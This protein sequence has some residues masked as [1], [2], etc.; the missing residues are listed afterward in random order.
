MLALSLVILTL[1]LAILV[2]LSK[3]ILQAFRLIGASKSGSSKW[4]IRSFIQATQKRRRALQ[5]AQSQKK[6]KEEISLSTLTNLKLCFMF[7]ALG[8]NDFDDW[9]AHN[10]EVVQSLLDV[11]D[12]RNTRITALPKLDTLIQRRISLMKARDETQRKIA[13]V[14]TKAASRERGDRTKKG[15]SSNTFAVK[16]ESVSDKDRKNPSGWAEEELLRSLGQ[17]NDEL[18]LTMRDTQGVLDEI[19]EL[20]LRSITSSQQGASGSQNIDDSILH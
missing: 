18:L 20:L 6:I 17:I 11:A 12:E 15:S 1:A 10:Q 9:V 3:I 16:S 14:R 19:V 5:L 8:D 4:G 7:K 13:R 2:F